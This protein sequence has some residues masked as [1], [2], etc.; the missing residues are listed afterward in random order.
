MPVARTELEVRL[1]TA[2]KRIA[3]YQPLHKLRDAEKLYGCDG[4]EVVE[5]AYENVLGEAKNALQGVRLP[6][7]AI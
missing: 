6:R 1:Y 4:G 3:A 7:S 2:L 5:M